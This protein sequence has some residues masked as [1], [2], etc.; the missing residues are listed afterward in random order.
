[1]VH[2]LPRVAF[3]ADRYNSASLEFL[4]DVT[5]G[6]G[7]CIIQRCLTD[8]ELLQAEPLDQ[9]PE[10]NKPEDAYIATRLKVRN[11]FRTRLA[12]RV[13]RK[14]K[15]AK[16]HGL[17][18]KGDEMWIH[19]R[20]NPDE[21]QNWRIRNRCTTAERDESKEHIAPGSRDGNNE[22]RR[23]EAPNSSLLCVSEKEVTDETP[24][25]WLGRPPTLT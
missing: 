6:A 3:E 23:Q 16:A 15:R 24:D 13:Q 1:M 18:N 21:L 19:C 4:R 10:E 9:V 20:P 14:V 11:N 12:T 2:S 8:D 7:K 17:Y 25:T 5:E 22:N